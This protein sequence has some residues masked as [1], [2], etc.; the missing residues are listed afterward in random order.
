MALELER[1][2]ETVTG[3]LLLDEIHRPPSMLAA[4]GRGERGG[5]LIEIAREYLPPADLT[6]LDAALAEHGDADLDRVLAAVADQVQ[7]NAI[8]EQV[9]RYEH[10]VRIAVDYQAPPPQAPMALLRTASSYHRAP[11]TM[12]R[13]RLVPGDH[14]SMLRP[15]HVDAVAAAMREVLAEFAATP[16]P[17]GAGFQPA[18]PAFVPAS[19][20]RSEAETG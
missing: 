10:N 15:P 6:A 9:R 11:E 14:Y 20:H 18:M 8:G 4:S 7:R 12:A 2:G 16:I 13:I 5:L 17:S 1:R 19:A 3:L